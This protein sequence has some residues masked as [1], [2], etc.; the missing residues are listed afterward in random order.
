MFIGHTVGKPRQI[1]VALS[2][3]QIKVLKALAQAECGL[4]RVALCAV[5]F[6]LTP[7]QAAR[8]RALTNSQQASLSRSLR[9]LLLHR[10]VYPVGT[11]GLALSDNGQYVVEELALIPSRRLPGSQQVTCPYCYRTE[12]QV[13]DG[14]NQSGSQR[15]RCQHCRRRYT[16]KPSPHGYGADKRQQAIHMH[17]QTSQS[18]EK[19]QSLRKIARQLGVDHH[20]VANW[21]KAHARRSP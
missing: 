4:P 21:V 20:T 3:K 8:R 12:R 19:R 13:K 18:D 10:L 9:S 14:L 6:D 17:R 11:D 7:E 1:I 2:R 16:P 15:Y 5:F